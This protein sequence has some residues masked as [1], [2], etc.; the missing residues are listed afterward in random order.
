MGISKQ[1]DLDDEFLLMK[2]GVIVRQLLLPGLVKDA[3]S[4]VKYLY[5]TYGDSIYLSLMSQFTPLPHIKNCPELNRKVTPEEYEEYV[6]Y[7]IELGVE[8][9]FIQEE[10]VAEESFIPAFDCEGV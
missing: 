7:A 5:E 9:G 8:N 10:D 6:D 4:S 1:E 3:N 2:K